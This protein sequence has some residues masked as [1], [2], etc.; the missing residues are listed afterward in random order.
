MDWKRDFARQLIEAGA[1][2]LLFHG[3]P[4]FSAI[5]TYRDKPVFHSF[6]N[7]IFH[8]PTWVLPDAWE[9]CVAEMLLTEEGVHGVRLIPFVLADENG[10][11][12]S[13]K[14]TR[15]YPTQVHGERA[16]RILRQVVA[17]SAEV[18]TRLIIEGDEALLSL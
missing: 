18:G 8:S 12:D 14:A 16:Q 6:G 3:V 10:L 9:G 11:E 5:E 17:E 13:P 2:V 1:D 4:R 7:F 15:L